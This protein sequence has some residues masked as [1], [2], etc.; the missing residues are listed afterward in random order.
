[1]SLRQI[2]AEMGTSKST[3]ARLLDEEQAPLL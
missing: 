1:M 2:A 3:A